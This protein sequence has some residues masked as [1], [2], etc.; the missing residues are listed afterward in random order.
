[1]CLPPNLLPISSPHMRS[2]QSDK[3]QRYLAS[4]EELRAEKAELEARLEKIEEALAGSPGSVK[5][6][7]RGRTARRGGGRRGRRN[8]LSLRAAVTQ[9]TRNR[10]LS[11]AE[12]LEAVQ[13]IGYKFA[14]KDPLNSLNAMLYAPANKFRNQNGK[15][16]PK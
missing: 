1:M 2:P 8:G 14:T 3:L 13:K 11:K 12:I 9:A 6:A 10:P 15:F 16:S 7:R 5:G 4:L